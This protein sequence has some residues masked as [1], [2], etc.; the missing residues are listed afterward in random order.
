[1]VCIVSTWRPYWSL[2]KTSS[3]GVRQNHFT[4]HSILGWY[5]A[6]CACHGCYS[7]GK[8][9]SLSQLKFHTSYFQFRPPRRCVQRTWRHHAHTDMRMSIHRC[10]RAH[11]RRV[12]FFVLC[13]PPWVQTKEKKKSTAM[14]E[15]S[16]EVTKATEARNATRRRSVKQTNVS[17]RTLF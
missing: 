1:M 4:G 5:L 7:M 13:P 3:M 9:V 15:T 17:V 16:A 10:G 2:R 11:T 8:K 6:I 12:F 14:K